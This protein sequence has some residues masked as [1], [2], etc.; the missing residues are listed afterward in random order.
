[1]DSLIPMLTTAAFWTETGIYAPE[2]FINFG[3]LSFACCW[4]RTSDSLQFLCHWQYAEAIL[5]IF[6]ETRFVAEHWLATFIILCWMN[7]RKDALHFSVL[8]VAGCPSGVRRE[9]YCPLCS[10]V[11]SDC[12]QQ[13]QCRPGWSL[14]VLLT[15]GNFTF[16][17]LKKSSEM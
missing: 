14:S 6:S 7:Y 12:T 15:A 1:M 11:C 9:L 8:Q 2:R 16:F 4:S 5:L 13:T 17:F 3:C 10:I